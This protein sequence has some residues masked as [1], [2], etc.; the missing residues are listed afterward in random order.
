MFGRHNIRLP[1]FASKV[2]Y[3]ASP[4]S[5]AKYSRNASCCFATIAMLLGQKRVEIFLDFEHPTFYALSRIYALKVETIDV[6]FVQTKHK[7]FL[8][9]KFGLYGGFSIRP[10]WDA[11]DCTSILNL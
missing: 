10:A 3:S 1:H 2:S 4:Q 8:S 9:E 7:Y 5:S 6:I 11:Y